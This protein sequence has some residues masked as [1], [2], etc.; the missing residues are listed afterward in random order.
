[1]PLLI[2]SDGEGKFIFTDRSRYVGAWI[3][4][5]RHGRVE[6][7]Y[8]NGASFKSKWKKGKVKGS[9]KWTSAP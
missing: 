9:K 2:I 7:F 4:S 3:A 6:Y 5:N 1:V 8:A